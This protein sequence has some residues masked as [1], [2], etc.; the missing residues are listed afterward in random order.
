MPNR[1]YFQTIRIYDFCIRGIADTPHTPTTQY[2]SI[3]IVFQLSLY[4]LLL[5]LPIP[6]ALSQL[7]SLS[8]HPL[9]P[10]LTLYH[11]SLYILLPSISL[12]LIPKSLCSYQSLVFH[13][14]SFHRFLL[15]NSHYI[16]IYNAHA[17]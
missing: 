15:I 5:L 3:S 11:I 17:R 13:L 1:G 4:L 10:F 7:S 8:P 2:S 12:S 6:I 14:S 16:I 9:T